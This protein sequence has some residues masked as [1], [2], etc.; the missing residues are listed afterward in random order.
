[1]LVKSATMRKKPRDLYSMQKHGLEFPDWLWRMIKEGKQR[2]A[3]A[4]RT[5]Y[6][7]HALM[8]QAKREGFWQPY[9]DI[10]DRQVQ[11]EKTV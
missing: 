9:Q 5:E 1:M 11:H 3:K 8:E 4:S 10:L 6:I 7:K 2:T